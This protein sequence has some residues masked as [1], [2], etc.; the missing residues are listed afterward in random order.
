MSGVSILPLLV[1][2]AHLVHTFEPVPQQR[3][4]ERFKVKGHHVNT[5]ILA[6]S[7]PAAPYSCK[8]LAS[9]AF[10]DHRVSYIYCFN[11]YR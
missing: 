7:S 8:R 9:G 11:A 1:S 4:P 6:I 3:V 2:E 5:D 10:A